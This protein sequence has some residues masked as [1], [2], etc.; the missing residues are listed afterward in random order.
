[1]REFDTVGL[2]RTR[3]SFP[4]DSFEDVVRKWKLANA[5]MEQNLFKVELDEELDN[6]ALTELANLPVGEDWVKMIQAEEA[7]RDGPRGSEGTR[8]RVLRGVGSSV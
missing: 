8:R 1:M 7:R 4:G 6:D 3:S 2:S 5:A